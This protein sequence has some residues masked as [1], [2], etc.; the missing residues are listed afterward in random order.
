MTDTIAELRELLAEYYS[1]DKGDREIAYDA[2]SCYRT[3]LP[4]LLDRVEA[5]ERRIAEME[6]ALQPFADIVDTID[7]VGRADETDDRVNVVQAYGCLLAELTEDHFRA[8]AAALQQK[9][10]TP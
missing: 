6:E 3:Y 4:A 10:D 7:E 2:L 8:A 5:G 9:A 1:R